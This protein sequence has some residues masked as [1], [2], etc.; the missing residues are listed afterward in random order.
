MSATMTEKALP[1]LDADTE[2][3]RLTRRRNN[4]LRRLLDDHRERRGKG[5]TAL[6]PPGKGRHLPHVALL[7]PENVFRIANR[8]AG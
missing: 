5:M 3:A 8:A 4:G 7:R 6:I 1:D 2:I